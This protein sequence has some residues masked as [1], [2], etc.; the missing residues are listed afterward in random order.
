MKRLANKL[1]GK[2]KTE[3]SPV[4]HA[5][6]SF[7]KG[8]GD[9]GLSSLPSILEACSVTSQNALGSTIETL[10]LITHYFGQRQHLARQA[11]CVDLLRYMSDSNEIE[12]FP[13]ISQNLT[14]LSLLERNAMAMANGEASTSPQSA[15]HLEGMTRILIDHFC[16]KADVP[17][18][19]TALQQKLNV[20]A[21]RTRRS[22]QSQRPANERD[23]AVREVRQ[24]QLMED[25]QSAKAECELMSLLL[26]DSAGKQADQD[27][28]NLDEELYESLIKRREI[29]AKHA[30]SR[31]TDE[32]MLQLV[33]ASE[34][35]ETTLQLYSDYKDAE[36]KSLKNGKQKDNTW[37]G[38]DTFGGTP[39]MSY[40]APSPIDKSRQGQEA[41]PAND[42]AFEDY[43]HAHGYTSHQTGYLDASRSD[44]GAPG[45]SGP[46]SRYVEMGDEPAEYRSTTPAPIDTAVPA[47]TASQWSPRSNNPFNNNP[48]TRRQSQEQP[49]QP[50]KTNP[51]L[52]NTLCDIATLGLPYGLECLESGSIFK[53]RLTTKLRAAVFRSR[54]VLVF[55]IQTVRVI[56]ASAEVLG[57]GETLIAQPS[58][59]YTALIGGRLGKG[60]AAK[61][62]R[63]A[64]YGRSTSTSKFKGMDLMRM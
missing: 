45:S 26:S 34:Q 8:T 15:R 11:R 18:Q 7:I 9:Q 49:K 12:L 1:S 42:Q 62:L 5:T 63:W 13:L 33:G 39:T 43:R 16:L 10:D 54:G 57:L 14:F 4:A 2:N 46:S 48:F 56:A 44:D 38:L 53:F 61:A 37:Q 52:P 6:K 32:Q 22:T 51:F 55:K 23:Q 60:V 30:E 58:N 41:W 17:Q 19:I 25:V 3:D 35:I 20:G 40:S 64:V 31:L 50:A 27:S 28:E 29:L 24:A 21:T 59:G 47:N 36:R